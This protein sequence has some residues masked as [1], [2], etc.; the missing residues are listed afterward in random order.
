MSAVYD[1]ETTQVWEGGT[2]TGT[3][4][5]AIKL[6][7]VDTAFTNLDA[8]DAMT[9]EP[10]STGA[11]IIGSTPLEAAYL[12]ICHPHVRYDISKMTGFNPV[13]T[14]ASHV[15]TYTG[16]FGEINGVRWVSSS[17]CPVAADAGAGNALLR[18]TTNAAVNVDVYSSFIYAMNA[19]GS[20]GLGENHTKEI[21]MEGTKPAT[22][23]VIHHAMDSGGLSNPFNEVGGIAWKAWWAG[24]VLDSNLLFKVESGAT[25]PA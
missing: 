15:S 1:A 4:D 6:V 19:V 10:M 18:G 14:Y 11:T 7:T 9:F 22:I 16:E 2:N 13:S 21:Y 20:V 12:G 17:N 8:Y 5:E 3:V 24:K 25:I 23:E